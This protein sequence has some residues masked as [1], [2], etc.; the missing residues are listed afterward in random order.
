[1]HISVSL[2]IPG[3]LI[4]YPKRGKCEA[5]EGDAMKA[6]LKAVHKERATKLRL[7]SWVNP[8]SIEGIIKD[9]SSGRRRIVAT[10]RCEECK[11]DLERGDA[12][13]VEVE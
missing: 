2:S 10:F 1:M 4:D 12:A 7:R 8:T 13:I 11:A 9:V 5:L 3:C 6:Y